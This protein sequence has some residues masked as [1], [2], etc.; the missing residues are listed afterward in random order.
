MRW[1]SLRNKSGRDRVALLLAA[2]LFTAVA[3]ASV[4]ILYATIVN[5]RRSV[6]DATT[7]LLTAL[8]GGIVGILG[9]YIGTKH[10]DDDQGGDD[11]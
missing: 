5:E 2:A 11:K 9:A 7:Q 8:F 4:S 10:D 3:F 6:T 1:P